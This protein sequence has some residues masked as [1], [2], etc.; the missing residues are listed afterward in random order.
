M[1]PITMIVE[2]TKMEPRR[3]TLSSTHGMKGNERIAPSE[4]AAAMMPFSEPCGLW[5]STVE[6]QLTHSDSIKM[7]IS[8]KFSK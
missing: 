7:E 1:A 5:K 2:P 8:Y 6:N 3:P 4:Y